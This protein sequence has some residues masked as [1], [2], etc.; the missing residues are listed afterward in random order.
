MREHGNKM[1]R[2]SGHQKEEVKWKKLHKNEL[3]IYNIN[4]ILFGWDGLDM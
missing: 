1:L 3:L 4:L 2:I